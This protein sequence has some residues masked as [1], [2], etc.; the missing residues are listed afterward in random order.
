MIRFEIK[1]L[2]DTIVKNTI[3]YTKKINYKYF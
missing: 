3:S 1:Y 2:L